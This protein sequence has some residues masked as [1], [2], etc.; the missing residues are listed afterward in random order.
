MRRM[1][2]AAY[3]P[4]RLRPETAPK[5]WHPRPRLAFAACVSVLIPRYR[6][7]LSEGKQEIRQKPAP[8][9]FP[10]PS[11]SYPLALVPV[12]VDELAKLLTDCPGCTRWETTDDDAAGN[13]D[14]E[15]RGVSATEDE[16]AHER[17]PLLNLDSRGSRR[18]LRLC[19]L[20]HSCLLR[21]TS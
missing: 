6:H 15:E 11:S 7:Q 20:Y 12:V 17:P 1:A 3:E 14:E 2:L 9:V 5:I 13:G 19:F 8:P 18:S 10:P 21:S 4:T 16:R